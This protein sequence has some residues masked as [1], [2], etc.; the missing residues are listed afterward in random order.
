[1]L[2]TVIEDRRTIRLNKKDLEN[3]LSNKLNSHYS[4][5]DSEKSW[6]FK[7]SDSTNWR[8]ELV[9]KNESETDIVITKLNKDET[10]E[11]KLKDIILK[12][13][14]IIIFL[15]IV[16]ITI[17]ISIRL[18]CVI[19]TF[20]G[21]HNIIGVF[22]GAILVYALKDTILAVQRK[23][24]NKKYSRALNELVGIIDKTEEEN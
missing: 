3:E 19:C 12:I 11:A 21:I 20:I 14:K 18:C 15:V 2:G 1:M 7:S 23:A 5:T 8:V 9:G 13:I 10:N 6:Q 17:D 16:Y 4:S 22:A 24:L